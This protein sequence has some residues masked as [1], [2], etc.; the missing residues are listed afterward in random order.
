M[1]RQ[2]YVSKEVTHFV[3]SGLKEEEEQ[4]SV[5]VHGI[6]KSGWLKY[7][8]ENPDPVEVLREKAFVYSKGPSASVE[9]M[10]TPYVVC[11]CD[12]P[13]SD[14]EIHMSKYSHFGLS[15]TK[16]FLIEKGACPVF[17][18]AEN[19]GTLS[20][21]GM[22]EELAA[23]FK[24]VYPRDL[25]FRQNINNYLDLFRKLASPRGSS[26]F[27]EPGPIHLTEEDKR[28][29][30]SIQ[31]FLDVNIF[32]FLKYFDA[33]ASDENPRNVYMEREWRVLGDVKFKLDDVCR[34]LIPS[35]YAKRFRTDLP[36]YSG[37]FTF[38]DL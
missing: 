26:P 18:V 20:L 4:Y 11:F 38:V 37:Q 33:K 30:R 29:L 31:F 14:F 2:R 23:R 5:L 1:V 16:T 36:E 15:F 3:G 28:D 34:V 17:Y 10:Y 24:N 7:S 25:A 35:K 27:T 9:D 12:I 6:L 32:S 19:S 8:P 22:P 21:G 13:I